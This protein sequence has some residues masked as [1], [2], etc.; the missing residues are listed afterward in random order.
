MA[1]NKCNCKT[2]PR[3]PF[4]I[5]NLVMACCVCIIGFGVTIAAGY[6]N[7]DRFLNSPGPLR[8]YSDKIVTAMLI[9]G[10]SCIVLSLLGCALI[11]VE[12]L[13]LPRCYGVLLIPCTLIF[14]ICSA[15]FHNLVNTSNKGLEGFCN[16]AVV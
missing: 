2:L 14:I 16:P 12:H 5:I 11:H 9:G 10:L 3:L 1:E 6:Y 7:T 8:V 13:A 4:A 15:M